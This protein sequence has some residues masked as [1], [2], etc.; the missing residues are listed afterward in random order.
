MGWQMDSHGNWTN[1]EGSGSKTGG[2]SNKTK[3]ATDKGNTSDTNSSISETTSNKTN[4]VQYAEEANF[5]AE[6]NYAIRRG[7]Y[8]KVGDGVASRWKGKWKI[9]ETTH[10]I[11]AR[12][13]KT[14][15][16]LGRIPYQ[17]DDS[18]SSSDSGSGSDK[19]DTKGNESDDT[20]SNDDSGGEWIMDSDGTWHKKA[21]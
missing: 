14:D 10:T 2:D 20:S 19:D 3:T 17:E 7:G 18:S 13:Y 8:F 21:K 9:L 16:V 6:G 15:G 4:E 12:G 5:S 11:D 1:T